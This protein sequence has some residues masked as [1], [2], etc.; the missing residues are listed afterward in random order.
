[1]ATGPDRKPLGRRETQKPFT[2]SL[3]CARL[4]AAVARAAGAAG[5]LHASPPESWNGWEVLILQS[6]KC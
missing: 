2:A 5:T 3:A 4:R 1:M 6:L